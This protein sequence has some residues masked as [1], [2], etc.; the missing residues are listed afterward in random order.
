M[1][2][3]NTG[4]VHGKSQP[5]GILGYIGDD[6]I[7]KPIGG[8]TAI[9]F[10][11]P[12]TSRNTQG[13]IPEKA[14]GITCNLLQNGFGRW[15][16]GVWLPYTEDKTT[17]AVQNSFTGADTLWIYGDSV[18]QN[19][20]KSLRLRGICEKIFKKCKDSYMWIYEL[21][22]KQEA[23]TKFR[24]N[25]FNKTVILQYFTNILDS[26]DMRRQ[27]SVFLFNLG[28]HHSISLNFTTYR[29]LVD[30]VITLLRRKVEVQHNNKP[31]VIWKTTTAI[32]KEKTLMFAVKTHWR[33]HT[34]QRLELFHKYATN[35]MCKAGIP[36]LDV[37][38]MT[39]SYPNGTLDH[40]HYN[41]NAQRAAEDQLLAF[42]M[43]EIKK[44]SS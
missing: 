10:S 28:V 15:V 37:Y 9:T 7:R 11:V 29:D 36:V 18:A 33:F 19:F 41:A 38:P 16:D 4:T 42:I 1:I 35:A 32:E 40:V 31:I 26:P 30:S 34:Y 23:T 12:E 2:P 43:E 22:N 5:E 13:F 21:T 17:A 24:P 20:L 3:Q 27:N 25:D 14:C 8:K 6:Y 39:A 44:T